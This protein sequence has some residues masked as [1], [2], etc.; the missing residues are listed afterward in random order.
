M[1][2]C[3]E[4]LAAD[5]PRQIGGYRLQARLGAGGMGRV[6]LGYSP[7]GRPVA[8]KVVHP[9]L[10]RD[11]EVMSRFRR[12]VAAAQA[13]S[14]AYTAA[15]VGAGPDDSPP[16]LATTFVPGPPLA[17]LV[18]QAGPLGED[19]VW[20]L[21]GRPGRG[22][23][24][25]PRR[26]AGY[27][28]TSSPPT[29]CSPPMARASSTSASPGRRAA[30]ARSP[31]PRRRSAPPPTCHPSRPK[32]LHRRAGQ[33]R[34][35]ARQRPGIRRDRRGAVRRGRD[36][37][38][39]L[40]GRAR[41]AGPDRRPGVAAAGDRRLPG[42]GPRRPASPRPAD[43]DGGRQRRGLPGRHAGELLARPGWRRCRNRARWCPSCRPP[44]TSRP[45]ARRRTP[46]TPVRTRFYSSRAVH[47]APFGTVP[48]ARGGGRATR[49]PP[50]AAGARAGCCRSPS[51][52]RW[53]SGPR[54][55]SRWR[56]APGR[57]P[58]RSSPG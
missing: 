25:D 45:P 23:A 35:L 49:L 1:V 46:C 22:A 47:A 24:G 56:L 2:A 4:P 51:P 7:G 39:R 26:G 29:S 8:L 10:A 9:E 12:E 42:E 32:A 40:P 5:D 6:Y 27:T 33:R 53:S 20:R 21:A 57:R 13:V 48:A 36:V 41:R 44:R 54:S 52:S 38:G 31:R 11:P 43:G 18:T 55:R 58:R 17:D 34:L 19:A 14:D 37:R 50:Q 16:W 15:V 3:V 28:A 30:P